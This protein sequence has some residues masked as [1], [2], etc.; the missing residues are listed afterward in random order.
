MQ[1]PQLLLFKFRRD[2]LDQ[3]L[4]NEWPKFVT[5]ITAEVQE[6]NSSNLIDFA[7]ESH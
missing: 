7:M 3:K 6:G 2:N 4:R 5:V 1:C